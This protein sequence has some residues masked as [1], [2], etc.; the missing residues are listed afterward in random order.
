MPLIAA[1][2]ISVA[3]AGEDPKVVNPIWVSAPVAT[4]ADYP[5]F[6]AIIRAEGHVVVQCEAL[7][8]GALS[9]CTA[10]S[11]KPA[12]LGFGREAVRVVQ[13]GVL[14]PRTGDG[15]SE[16]SRIQV[17]LPFRM[18]ARTPSTK[19]APWTGP[20]PTAG[21][22]A[23][24]QRWAVR[25]T[26][27]RPILSRFGLEDLPP[28]R[29]AVVTEWI[30]ELYPDRQKTQAIFTVAAA[31]L[32]AEVGLPEMPPTRPLDEETWS[33]RFAAASA[34]QFDRHAADAELRRRYCARYECAPGL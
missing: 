11:E 28:D 14:A 34:D 18:P 17:Q 26:A 3:L 13:R 2:L 23:S 6:A 27:R 31:R 9:A 15:T 16:P 22:Q 29:R 24:A 8:T 25:A 5:R 30:G 32:L 19:P 1:L 12:D 10:M 7:P 21:Q 33:R 20:E 4:A